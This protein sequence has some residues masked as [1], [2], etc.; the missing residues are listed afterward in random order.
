MNKID[1]VEMSAKQPGQ[2][3]KKRVPRK[4]RH[5]IVG[6]LNRPWTTH[7]IMTCLI[8]TWLAQGDTAERADDHNHKWRCAPDSQEDKADEDDA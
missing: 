4:P 2:G 1:G 6:S 3:E 5:S 8:V 7:L